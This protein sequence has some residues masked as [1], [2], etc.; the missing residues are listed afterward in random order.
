MNIG[1]SF[2]IGLGLGLALCMVLIWFKDHKRTQ[3]WQGVV[4]QIK[5]HCH[6]V[7]SVEQGEDSQ[8]YGYV[9]VY[10][11]TDLGD[12]GCFKVSEQVFAKL[13]PD[14]QVSDRLLKEAGEDLPQTALHST[15]FCFHPKH[16]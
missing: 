6:Y 3:P 1:M 11:C 10:Y 14:L 9:V 8:E 2:L 5:R 13:Y 16:S 4:T 12:S 7:P 15:T